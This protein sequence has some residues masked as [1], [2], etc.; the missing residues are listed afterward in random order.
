MNEVDAIKGLINLF[1]GCEPFSGSNPLYSSVKFVPEYPLQ[2]M[3]IPTV[4]LSVSG[5]PQSRTRGIGSYWRKAKPRLQLD[6]LA[7]TRIETLRIFQHVRQVL[8]ADYENNNDSGELGLGYLRGLGIKWVML[9]EP[10]PATWDEQG[11][12]K[13]LTTQLQYEYLQEV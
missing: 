6:V 7:N 4:A 13:R 3:D 2:T 9:G 11:H 12:V 8:I 1:E 10:M 5:G